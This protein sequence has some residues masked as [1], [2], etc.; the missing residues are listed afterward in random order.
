MPEKILDKLDRQF[1]DLRI[2]VTDRCNFRCVYCMPKTIFGRDHVFLPREEILTYEE[3][4]RLVGIYVSLGAR[5]VRLTGGEPL[6]RPE[7]EKLIALLVQ[8][9]GVEDIAMTT[10]GSFPL[11]RVKSLKEVGLPRITVSLDSLDDKVFKAM[12][13]V[14]FP[15]E[16]VLEWIDAGY[17]VS[18]FLGEFELQNFESNF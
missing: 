16:R 17:A 14:D 13:D 2:S 6:I 3:I 11:N 10:N 15:V 18:N 7:I 8:V 4:T 9:P 5:K 1:G 12:N